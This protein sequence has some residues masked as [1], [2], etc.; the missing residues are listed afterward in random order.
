MKKLVFIILMFVSLILIAE[1]TNTEETN[2]ISYAGWVT[3]PGANENNKK[4]LNR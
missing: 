4:P 3:G 2:W 1:E